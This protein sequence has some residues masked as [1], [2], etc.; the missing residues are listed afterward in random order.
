MFAPLAAKTQ[1]K[2]PASSNDK[3]THERWRQ[4]FTDSTAEHILFLQRTIGNR[5]TLRLLSQPTALVGLSPSQAKLPITTPSVPGSIQPKLMVGAVD[6]PLEQEADRVA[7]QVMRMPEPDT[8][9]SPALPGASPG[10]QRK[11]S[12]DGGCDQCQAGQS[13]DGDG[14]VQMKP[15]EADVSG[16]S[17]EPSIAP[18]IVHEVLR[19]PG[20]PLDPATRAFFEPRFGY[21]FGH[22]L[23]HVNDEAGQSAQAVQA[24]AYTVGSHIV[25][26]PGQHAPESVAGKRL[27]A[28][29]LVHVV[30]GPCSTPGTPAAAIKRKEVDNVWAIRGAQDWLEADRT[31]GAKRWA[32]ACLLNLNAVDSSQY[33]RVVQR[34]D[35]YKWFYN[36]AAVQGFTTRWALAA[37]VVASGAAQIAD[38]DLDHAVSNEEFDM[39]DVEL[40][41]AM[42][43][44]NQIIFDN[45]L[46]KLK[47]LIDGGPLRGP[48][49]LKWDMQVLAEEQSLVQSMYSRLSP[50]AV[51]QLDYM[52]RKKRLAGL[53]AWWTDADVVN[54]GP[55]NQAGKVPAFDEPH[56]TSVTD[57]WKYGMGLGNTF[58]P[59]GSGF[60]PAR[61]KM[62]TVGAGYQDGSEFAKVDTL[63]HLHRLDA[64][65]NPNHM[66][67]TDVAPIIGALTAHEKEVIVADGSADG[68]AYS[69]MFANHNLSEG[70]VKAALPSDPSWA[71]YNSAFVS[72]YKAA[73]DE[74]VK[75]RKKAEEEAISRERGPGKF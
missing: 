59:G 61:D 28:H 20:E 63:S 64:A 19:S 75:A 62:P 60:D 32:D 50:H 25:F 49:A 39:A 51:D 17:S 41:G 27:M 66:S 3:P 23:V 37:Y 30:Q 65:L 35:F 46:P 29:E 71:N 67:Y 31:S 43:E 55:F 10:V 40:Q 56:I 11:C 2:E 68:W 33:I 36:Y 13:D 45:V 69:I 53:G 7:E 1:S 8:P 74:L 6:D 16:R 44:G 26:A 18:P 38:M 12:C 22:V 14:R 70:L 57:R 58:T 21:D 4:E 34:R 9:A 73:L 54:K 42:R 52:A 5:A 48:A 15:A 72:R 24:K 47:K